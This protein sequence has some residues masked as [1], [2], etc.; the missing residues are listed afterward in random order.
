MSAKCIVH[1]RIAPYETSST[2]NCLLLLWW[3]SSGVVLRR[4]HQMSPLPTVSREL[5]PLLRVLY[6]EESKVS[7]DDIQPSRSGSAW[8]SSPVRSTSQRHLDH[9]V[10]RFV[11][12][13]SSPTPALGPDKAVDGGKS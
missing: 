3:P 4:C 13:M 2:W 8:G 9:G 1:N 12:H 10:V 7:H 11:S 5:H 6:A